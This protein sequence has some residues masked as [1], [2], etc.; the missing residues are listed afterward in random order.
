MVVRVL[1]LVG[2]RRSKF[3]YDLSVLYG[4]ACDGCVDLDR[5]RFEFHIAVVHLDGSWS[6]PSSLDEADG[7]DGALPPR[8]WSFPSAV[9]RLA[10][11]DLD[12]I[13]PHMFCVEGMTRFRSL[14][15]LLD[16]PLLGNHDHTIW[17]ATDK[18]ITKQILHANGIQ[19][20]QGELLQKF[21]CEWPTMKVPVVV[22]PCNEDN[23]RGI[24]LVKHEEDLKFAID[25]AFSF[26]SRVVV[27]EY[28]AGREV[29]A[30]VIEEDG[31]LTV[32]PKVEYFLKDIRTA[33]HKLQTDSSGNLLNKAI[34]AAKQDG[35]RQCPVD[36]SDVLHQ[37]IDAMVTKAH[38]VLKCRH[39]SLYDI[40]I[41]ENEQPFIL[42]AAFFC[43]FAPLSTITFMADH[44][45]R[46]DLKHPEL[47][48]S[49]L[50]RAAQEKSREMIRI[51]PD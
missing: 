26:D 34:V 24:S 20:P 31:G 21:H 25:H 35:D 46:D 40:R 30:G 39:Y 45:G 10:E 32:L 19:V 8:R 5:E 23:S 42:E 29:R 4:K 38:H 37:R 9:R 1:H 44:S 47:F 6:F 17:L 49:F 12:V 36:L 7:S 18:A 2:S 43:S 13:V 28:I 41:D 3:Y 33:A 27:E 48:H 15:D 51:R 50:E 14:V 11:L 22:K 16:I